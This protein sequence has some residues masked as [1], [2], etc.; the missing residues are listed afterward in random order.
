MKI[1]KLKTLPGQQGDKFTDLVVISV[2][3]S[4][5][6]N[7]QSDEQHK[8]NKVAWKVAPSP[9]SPQTTRSCRSAPSY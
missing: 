9:N 6:E 7:A 2:D 4:L 1:L 5:L 3:G 8:K